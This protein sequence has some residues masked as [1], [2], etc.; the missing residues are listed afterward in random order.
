MLTTSPRLAN[1]LS[2]A[3]PSAEHP[4]ARWLEHPPLGLHRLHAATA[5]PD[6]SSA[7]V[8][9]ALLC[10]E[11]HRGA[12]LRLEADGPVRVGG[13]VVLAVRLGLLWA[14]APCRVVEVVDETARTGFTYATLPGHPELGVERFLVQD[15]GN[16]PQFVVDAVSRP[17][18]WA[19]RMAPTV[20][21]RVQA[22]IT[23]RYLAAA[24]ELEG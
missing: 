23:R 24:L 6:G 10:W 8:A 12:G 15:T 7:R 17:A 14:V 2:A 22:A 19:I 1:R 20:S 4:P 16:G 18:A 11:V 3:A 13:T 21:R 5:L 9:A